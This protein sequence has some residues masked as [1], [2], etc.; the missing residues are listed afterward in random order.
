M[1]RGAVA[2]WCFAPNARGT[3][4]DWNYCFELTSPLAAPVALLVIAI[5]KRWMQRGLSEVQ[6]AVAPLAPAA[7]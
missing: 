4:I 6:R 3:R 7:H 5:F 1:I 2:V